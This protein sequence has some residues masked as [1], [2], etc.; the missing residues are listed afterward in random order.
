MTLNGQN[1]PLIQIQNVTKVYQMGDI[2]VRALRGVSLEVG[3]GELPLFYAGIRA[4]DLDP[5]EALHSE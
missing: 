5:V 2:Q 1:T 3:A 4:T